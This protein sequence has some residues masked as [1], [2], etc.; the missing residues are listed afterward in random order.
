MPTVAEQMAASAKEA[1]KLTRNYLV[2]ELNYTEQSLE[3]LE[4]VIDDYRIAVPE[5]ESPETLARLVRLW[6]AY[7]GEVIRKRLGGEWIE[8]EEA[9]ESAALTLGERTIEP[10]AQVRRRLEGGKAHDL[11]QFYN[12]LTS[13]GR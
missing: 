2:V 3:D 4:R 13:L 11:W 6:G 8:A 1:K 10:L 5:G 7:L 12:Q 9:G